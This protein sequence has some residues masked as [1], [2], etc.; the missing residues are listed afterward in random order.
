M[1]VSGAEIL[2]LNF[3]KDLRWFKID[4]RFLIFGYA[5]LLVKIYRTDFNELP[6]VIF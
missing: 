1:N 6:E 3:L 2:I 4:V 5:L